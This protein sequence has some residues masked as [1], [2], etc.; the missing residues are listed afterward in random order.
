MINNMLN[1]L[2]VVVA[3]VVENK[4][5]LVVEFYVDI[6]N[7][8]CLKDISF[9]EDDYKWLMGNYSKDLNSDFGREVS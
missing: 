4:P 7:G 1:R 5:C 6:L 3:E 2:D 8:T 9:S